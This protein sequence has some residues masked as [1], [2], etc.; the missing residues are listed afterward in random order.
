MPKYNTKQRSALLSFFEAHV[1]DTFSARQLTDALS[2]ESIS[3]S[4]VYRNLAEL[5]ADGVIRKSIRPGF[6][7]AMYQYMN[8]EGCIGSLHLSCKLCGRAFHMDSD[9]TQHLTEYLNAKEDF[10]LDKSG[11]ILYGLCGDCQEKQE[12]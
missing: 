2:A 3:V 12:I 7:D 4:A 1:D 11:T 8:A 9:I 6:R 5:E 10:M